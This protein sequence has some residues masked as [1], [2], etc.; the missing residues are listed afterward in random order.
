METATAHAGERWELGEEI[1]SGAIARVVRVRDRQSGHVYAAKLLH[2]RHERDAT[3]R[4]RFQREAELASRLAHANL[5][6]VWGTDM[7]AGHT[8][9]VMELVEGETLARKLARDAPLPESELLALADG[10]AGGLAYAHASGVIHRDLKPAN[11][12]LHRGSEPKIADF[13]MARASSFAEAD[14]G[15]LTVLGTPPYMAPECLDP[16]AVDPRTDLYALGCILH[17]CATGSPPFGGAT[18]FAVLDAH[19]NAPIPALPPAYSDGLRRLVAH[20]LAKAAGDRPQSA[21]AVQHEIAILRDPNHAAL[22]LTRPAAIAAAASGKCAGCGADVLAD[23]RVC[24]RCGLVPVVLE[25]GPNTV[26]VLGPGRISDKL[27]SERRD[28]LVQWL[29]ANEKVGFNVERLE[30]RIP[31]LPFVLVRN[32][33]ANTSRTIVDSL[34][35][36]GIEAEAMVGSPMRHRAMGKHVW[37]MSTRGF[38]LAAAIVLAPAIAYAPLAFALAPLLGVAF[39]IVYGIVRRSAASTT[40]KALPTA[41][42][43][44]PPGLAARV[45][46]LPALV[47]TIAQRRHREALGAVVGRVLTLLR[48]TTAEAAR[49]VGPELEHAINLACVAARRMDEIESMMGRRDFDPADAEHRALMQERD[50][51]AARLLDLTATLDALTARIAAAEARVGVQRGDDALASLRANVEALEEVQKL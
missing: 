22:A 17:E 26:L 5:V 19:R 2:P 31:R 38:T 6:R 46:Q 32:V 28:R 20:L 12:L 39:G 41:R 34:E 43:A 36:L 30:R 25:P 7:I 51:W 47:P 21:G 33:S 45:Q 10:I 15:A 44:L 40:V 13:G 48:S 11:I 49:E 1:G 4:T 14:K 37:R 23:V 29:R 50:M 9:L 27:D 8:A 35:R 18:P 42:P 24:F 3:A 16:L